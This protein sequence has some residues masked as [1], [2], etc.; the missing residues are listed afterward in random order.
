MKIGDLVRESGLSE[1]MLR[2]YEKLG[3]ICPERS[4]RGTRHYGK[5]DLEVARL[6]HYFRDL[7]IPLDTIAAIAKE[8]P[9]H[10]TGDSSGQAIGTMLDELADHLA[11]KA[12]KS[13]ALHRTIVEASKAVTACRGC[14]NKPGPKTCPE[15]PMGDAAEQ[16]AV[17]AMIW[18]TD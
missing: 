6:V 14:T 12:E 5:A 3:I 11:R 16:N 8:R 1:R 13:L 10:V 9:R 2:H 18:R 17:A 7:D 4:D 15:C